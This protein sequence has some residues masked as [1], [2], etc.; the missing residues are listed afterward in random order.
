MTYMLTTLGSISI[1][2]SAINL[3]LNTF[4]EW[5]QHRLGT[6][7]PRGLPRNFTSKLR[8]L[9]GVE[10]DEAWTDEQQ[11]EMRA[12]RLQLNDLNQTRVELFHGLVFMTGLNEDITIHIAKE[13]G[14]ELVRKTVERNYAEL[15]RF[16]DDLAAIM[17]RMADL[18]D[19]ILGFDDAD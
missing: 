13:E 1:A 16:R 17:H 7:L 9:K 14:N 2:W 3:I 15:R 5:N 11:A 18:Y 10:K 6:E 19:P 8:H 12:I 4:I